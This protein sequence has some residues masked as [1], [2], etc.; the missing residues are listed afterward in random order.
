MLTD[1]TQLDMGFEQEYAS[2]EELLFS[3]YVNELLVGGWLKKATYQPE[4]FT[5]SKEQ[6]VDVFIK[7]KNHNE[8]KQIKILNKHSYTADWELIWNKKASGIFYWLDGGVY[9]QGVF[10]YSKP[11][12]D[13]FIPFMAQN[14]DEGLTSYIDVKGEFVSQS[15]SSGITFPLNQKWIYNVLDLFIQKIV[16]SLSEKSIFAR[17][18]TPRTIITSEVYKKDYKKGNKK[19]GDSKLKYT[20]ILLEHWVKNKLAV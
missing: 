6:C 7:K 4:S 20:P 2:K 10:P 16:V 15:N 12:K 18:F 5:L 14:G 11:R 9:D 19:A 13:K 17:T 3:Y 1:F 8:S